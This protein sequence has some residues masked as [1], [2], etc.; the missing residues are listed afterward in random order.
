MQVLVSRAGAAILAAILA[1]F[2]CVP[3]ANAGVDQEGRVSGTHSADGSYSRLA[4]NGFSAN[5]GQCVI[6]SV[7]TSDWTNQHMVQSGLVRC[8]SAWLDNGMCTDGHTFVETENGS[9]YL[10][11]QGYTF[12]NNTQY[13]ATTYRQ[14]GTTFYGHINGAEKTLSGFGS[15][16]DIRAYAWGEATGSSYT[17]PA[18]SK[19]T[20][21]DWKRYDSSV[22]AWSYV[23]SSSAHHNS[24]MGY[25]WHPSTV[26]STGDFYVD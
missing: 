16:D 8:S 23:T 12:T 17:C 13:D 22:G 21:T 15:T 24:N 7:N 10:C 2:V 5:P 14:S 11:D 6:Y 3:A 9:T 20:F 19:G 18:P 26:S 1:T 4:G 25:C